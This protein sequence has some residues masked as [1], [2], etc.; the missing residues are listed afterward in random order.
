L[1]NDELIKCKIGNNNV[2]MLIDSGSR[3]NLLTEK[4]FEYLREK[5]AVM[6][7][8]RNKSENKF[9]AYAA[10]NLLEVV[11]VFEAPFKIQCGQELIATFFVIKNATQ[12]VLGRE[13]AIHLKI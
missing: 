10:N 13:T 6:W 12:S 4:D 11:N 9:R 3:F 7:N 2:L 1:E 5:H 8:I